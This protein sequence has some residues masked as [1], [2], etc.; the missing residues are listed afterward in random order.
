MLMPVVVFIWLAIC[1]G[2]LAILWRYK[3]TPAPDGAVP[4]TWPAGSAVARVPGKPTLIMLVHPR[5]TC[6]RAS[7]SEL[8]QI[9]NRAAGATATVVFVLPEGVDDAWGHGESWDRA[10]E[11]PHTTVFVD[12]G[13]VE[14]ARFGVAASGHTLLYDAAGALVFS[15]GVTGARG[16]EGNN[17]GRQEL[18][19]ALLPH[20]GGGG[21]PATT[22]VFGCALVE[23][24]Q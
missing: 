5:C 22:R 15:G 9:M 19:A 16:H 18:L 3:M 24:G 6:S 23:G 20:A 1:V 17:L 4:P 21:E 2:G 12:R 7:L 8:N 10:H 13:G 14:A 11:I